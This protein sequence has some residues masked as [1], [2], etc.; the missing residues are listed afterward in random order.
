M[1]PARAA[2]LLIADAPTVGAEA[3]LAA[4]EAVLARVPGRHVAVVDR[5]RDPARGGSSDRARLARLAALRAVTAAAGALLVVTGR[6][7][8]AQAAG[9]DGVQLPER[10]LPVAAVRAAFPRLR[11]GRSCHDRAG[12]LAAA[13]AGADWATLAPVR[14]PWSKKAPSGPPLGVDGF[15]RAVAGAG[16]PVYALGGIGPDLVAALADA[17]ASG[18]ATIGAV[19]GQ[20]DP[21][22]AAAALLAPWAAPR[23]DT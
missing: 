14:A 21:A 12:L 17:G 9:A 15:A 7:D 19:F 16:L 10:G 4:V 20:A 13:A 5:D 18:V 3:A 11:V 8:L 2:L 23:A 22:G 6:A 1:T